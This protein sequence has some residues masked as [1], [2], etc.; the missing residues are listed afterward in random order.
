MRC[1]MIK[2]RLFESNLEGRTI[3]REGDTDYF[4]L[5]D[6]YPVNLELEVRY[7]SRMQF[8]LCKA[9]LVRT[10]PVS[11]WVTVHFLNDTDLYSSVANVEI[12]LESKQLEV[13]HEE[14]YINIRLRDR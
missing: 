12:H 11:N 8:P 3:D 7:L 10:T 13:M 2:H 9:I 5:T 14:S 6:F 1:D 4:L